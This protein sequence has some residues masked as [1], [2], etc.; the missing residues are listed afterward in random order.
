MKLDKSYKVRVT[1]EQ[2]R[3]IQELL[4]KLGG[5]WF[6]GH[7]GKH[8][9]MLNADY[10]FLRDSMV[11][12]YAYE[13]GTNYFEDKPNHTEIQADDLIALLTDLSKSAES[14]LENIELTPE[15]EALPDE[16]KSSQTPITSFSFIDVL[17]KSAQSILTQDNAATANP[18][19]CVK[20]RK[21]V[22][23]VDK[24]YENDGYDWACL[25][26]QESWS[27]GDAFHDALDTFA[28]DLGE[29]EITING[30]EYEKVY[31]RFQERTVTTCFTREQAQRYIDENRHNL[32]NPFIYVE[33]FNRNPEMLAMRE[34]LIC[35]AENPTMFDAVMVTEGSI[36]E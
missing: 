16:L 24:D 35:L 14:P 3:K 33:S 32:K 17:K 26:D 23:G 11:L 15:F 10:L 12:T 28:N 1:P 20:E 21:K 27:D 2:S 4:F 22:F 36:D 5:G 18:A 34:L 13:R 31:Y 29:D 7:D 9:A 19:Y 25:A 6:G 8:P 30:S